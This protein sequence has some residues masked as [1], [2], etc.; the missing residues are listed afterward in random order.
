MDFRGLENLSDIHGTFTITRN[1]KVQ[2]LA[3]LEGLQHV[4][5]DVLIGDNPL[6][7]PED[8]EALLERVT[9]DGEISVW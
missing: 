1:P 7:P 5:G 4:H 9:V 6:L 8:V 2:S 3:G